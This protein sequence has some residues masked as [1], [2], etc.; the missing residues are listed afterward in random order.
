M[1]LHKLAHIKTYKS[2][3]CVKK[4]LGKLLWLSNWLLENQI[5]HKLQCL[6]GNGVQTLD[7]TDEKSVL[8]AVDQLRQEKIDFGKLYIL[9]DDGG[10][11][12]WPV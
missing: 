7:I 4:K 8:Q 1:F 6:T 12:E 3:G 9:R 2:F 5:P 10:G 11:E